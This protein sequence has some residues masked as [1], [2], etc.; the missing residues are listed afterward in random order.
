MPPRDLWSV[1]AI[2]VIS[3]RTN[4]SFYLSLLKVS[5]LGNTIMKNLLIYLALALSASLLLSCSKEEMT[6]RKIEG[7]W[8]LT[9]YESFEFLGSVKVGAEG[10]CNPFAPDGVNDKKI[11]IINSSGNEY[12]V[13]HYYWNQAKSEWRSSFEQHWIIDG[14]QILTRANEAPYTITYSSDSFTMERTEEIPIFTASLKE[15]EKK[16]YLYEKRVFKKMRE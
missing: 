3:T 15:T 13:T 14:D 5:S 16:D 2:S 4:H 1:F 11:V 8:G 12:L 9:H 7:T 10:D 6:K